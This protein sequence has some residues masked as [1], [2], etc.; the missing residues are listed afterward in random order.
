M[1]R[2]ENHIVLKESLY[3]LRGACIVMAQ[4][5]ISDD[6]EALMTGGFDIVEEQCSES[7]PDIEGLEDGPHS[8][9]TVGAEIREAV[10]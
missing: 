6:W 1:T 8:H 7:H 10:V 5:A 4:E 3:S 2:V 9:I